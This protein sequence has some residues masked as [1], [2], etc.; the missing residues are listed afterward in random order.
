MSL[1]MLAVTSLAVSKVPRK[2]L[3][4]SHSSV[5]G[6][7]NVTQLQDILR[8]LNNL[9]LRTG[10]NSSSQGVELNWMVSLLL[11]SIYTILQQV[12]W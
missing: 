2:D 4:M 3:E 6:C 8:L 11:K 7:A 1:V 5:T 9:K 10:N 12:I